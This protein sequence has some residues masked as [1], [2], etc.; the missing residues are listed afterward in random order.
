MKDGSIQILYAN[1]NYAFCKKNSGTWITTNNK[2]LRRGRRVR[3]NSEY[4][5]DPIP[6]A[7]KTD[8]ETGCN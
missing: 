3:D 8:P 1:G 7:R 4:E 6:S 5:L 2:G